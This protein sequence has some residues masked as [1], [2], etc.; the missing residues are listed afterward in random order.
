MDL[1][2]SRQVFEKKSQKSSFIKILPVGAEL[3]QADRHDE[4]NSR[5][6]VIFPTRLKLAKW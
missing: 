2:F 3:L 6:S 5:F 4:A 1:E